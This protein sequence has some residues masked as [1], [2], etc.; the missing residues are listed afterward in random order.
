MNF[1]E[2]TLQWVNQMLLSDMIRLRDIP[3]GV[4][5]GSKS[6]Y[7]TALRISNGLSCERFVQDLKIFTQDIYTLPNDQPIRRSLINTLQNRLEINEYEGEELIESFKKD[8]YPEVLLELQR[9]EQAVQ[10]MFRERF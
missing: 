9:S 8:L 5:T 10:T 6:F 2:S 3:K 1:Y 7:V 4:R